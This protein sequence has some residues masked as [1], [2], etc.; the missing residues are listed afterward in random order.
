MK[1]NSNRLRNKF[2]DALHE[3]VA[4]ISETEFSRLIKA[5]QYLNKRI[6]RK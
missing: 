1:L 3:G 5:Y 2:R 4:P 6:L